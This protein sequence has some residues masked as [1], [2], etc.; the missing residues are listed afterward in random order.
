MGSRP[1]DDRDRIDVDTSPTEH[2][3]DVA[4]EESNTGERPQGHDGWSDPSIG[5]A[6]RPSAE[7][8]L[9]ADMGV[10]PDEEALDR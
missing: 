6:D 9:A 1:M 7:D 2:E 3:R 4:E 10:D 5:T 8:D